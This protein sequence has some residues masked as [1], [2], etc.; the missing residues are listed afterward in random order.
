[1]VAIG[2]EMVNSRSGERFVWRATRESTGG[3]YCEF[4]LYL[5]PGARVAAAH[6]HPNQEERVT[7]VSGSLALVKGNARTV[8]GPG[9]EG[10]IP[11][12]TAH[13]WGN[14]G[15]L[16]HAIVRLSPALHIEEFFAMFCLLAAEG[17]ANA[18]GLPRNPLR[19]AVLLDAYREEFDFATEAQHR[20]LSAPLAA[21]TAIGRTLGLRSGHPPAWPRLGRD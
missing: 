16:S 11:P 9:D 14:A 17:K 10:V 1:M 5:A 13:R 15:E 21:L 3:E 6:R 20:M 2:D 7:T 19:M 12:G 4:D 8:L 18:A